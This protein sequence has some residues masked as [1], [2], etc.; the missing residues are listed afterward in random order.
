MSNSIQIAAHPFGTNIS[1][2]DILETLSFFDDWEER[3]KYIIDLGRELPALDA[4]YQIDKH[5]VSGCQSQ[6][7]IISQEQDGRLLLQADSDAV[8]VKGLLALVLAAYHKQSKAD[9]LSFDI[10]GYFNQL[11]LIKHLSATRGNGLRAMIA[12]IKQLA[13]S[14]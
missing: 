12:H 2:D 11:K 7:W 5:K 9:I 4:Q 3:Y 6:V 1:C 13:N 10:E 14:M 8:I